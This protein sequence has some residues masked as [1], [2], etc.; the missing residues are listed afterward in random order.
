MDGRFQIAEAEIALHDKIPDGIE[1]GVFSVNG[2]AFGDHGITG[3]GTTYYIFR[4]C[5]HFCNL[6]I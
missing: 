5:G 2:E 3:G 1:S 6:V 4:G